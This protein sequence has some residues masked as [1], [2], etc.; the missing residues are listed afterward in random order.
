MSLQNL[1]EMVG[2]FFSDVFY[3]KVVNNQR[4]LYW[5]CVL[6]PKAGYQFALYV[7]VFVLSLFKEFV[8]Q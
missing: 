7:T 5:P 1:F 8:C 3:S 4:E 2:M 6:S